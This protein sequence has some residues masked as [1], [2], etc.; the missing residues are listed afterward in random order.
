VISFCFKKSELKLKYAEANWLS[1]EVMLIAGT[2]ASGGRSLRTC[3]TFE[4]MSASALVESKLSRRWALIVESPCPL[5]DS[6]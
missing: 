4:L 3:S 5:V 6:M 1:E 2:C